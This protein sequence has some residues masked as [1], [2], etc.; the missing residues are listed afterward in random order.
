MGKPVDRRWANLDLRVSYY[1]WGFYKKENPVYKPPQALWSVFISVGSLCA[2]LLPTELHIVQNTLNQ[3]FFFFFNLKMPI[4]FYFGCTEAL[5]QCVQYKGFSCWGT[6]AL[7][8]SLSNS[9]VGLIALNY[10]G[11]WK[12]Q[13]TPVFLPGESCGWRS[14]VGCC[15]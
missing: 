9:S 14:L 6:R 8:H 2:F 13:P 5:L 11:S 12:W 15:P 10:V 4:F 7:E 3:A 1:S